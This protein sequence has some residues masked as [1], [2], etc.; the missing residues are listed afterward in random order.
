MGDARIPA[1]ADVGLDLVPGYRILP[2]TGLEDP[3]WRQRHFDWHENVRD[4]RVWAQERYVGDPDFRENLFTLCERDAAFF[5]LTFM[6]VEEPRSMEYFDPAGTSLEDAL[7]GLHDESW[8]IGLDDLS[9]R[10][11]HPYLLFAYQIDAMRLLTYTILGPLRG[12]YHDV[13]WDKPRGIGMSYT[14]LAWSY[15]AWLFI[16]GIRGTIL[17][18]KWDKAERSND[19]NTLFGKLDLFLDSTPEALMPAGFRDKGEKAAHRQRGSLVNPRTGAA[20]FTEPTTAD[21]TRGGREAFVMIDEPA[22]HEFLDETWATV[23]GTT[24]HRI[25][26]SSANYRYGR[27][28]E[29]KVQ[30]GKKHP[31]A[32]TV[33]TLD[34]YE[35]PHQGPEWYEAERE[36]FRAAGQEEQFEVEYL[37]NAAAGSGRLVYKAQLA[38]TTWTDKGYDKSKPLKV[39]VDP[40]TADFTA[41]SFWQ[42]H[43]DSGKKVIRWIEATRLA[44]VPVQFWAHVMTGIEPR[45]AGR[46]EQGEHEADPAYRYLKEGFFDEGNIRTVM[47]W[48]KTVSPQSIML[49]GDPSMRREDVT[50]ES[51]IS[52]FEKETL[53]LRRRAFGADSPNAIPIFCNLPWKILNKR[54]N[55]QDRRAGMREALMMSEFSKG[56]TGVEELYEALANTMFQEITERNTRPPGH[57]HDLGS[58]YTTSAEYGMIWETLKL[59]Q[60]ELRPERLGKIEQPKNMR[61][62][63][64]GATRHVRQRRV[65]AR[66]SLVGLA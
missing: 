33:R 16:P 1:L 17:T 51:W 58:D 50:R 52:I 23:G 63:R 31:R 65:T 8:D 10:T 2:E 45:G 32:C 15:W 57:I 62:S 38:L 9:Y 30:N 20:L 29:R 21:S 7:A 13:L 53:M 26:W 64:Y 40:G 27:Q 18:E 3:T 14:A 6:D 4:W 60:D 41:F 25:G 46:D 35:H 42:T 43:Y 11:I 66:E 61:R 54:N 19:L 36:R 44:K 39:S 12:Y 49:Y 47:A 55:F 34:W 37:R 22:F 24:K 5:C 48:M 56:S 28:W 59:T